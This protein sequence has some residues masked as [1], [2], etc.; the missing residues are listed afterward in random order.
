MGQALELEPCEDPLHSVAA[1]DA[2]D[3]KAGVYEAV[4]KPL[5][6]WG[7]LHISKADSIYPYMY[8][9]MLM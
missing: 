4:N 7:K 9:C 3:K 5:G 8:N 2:V 1:R 6:P